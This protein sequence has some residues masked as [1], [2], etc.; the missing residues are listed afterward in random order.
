MSF[1]SAAPGH[2][3]QVN[4][5]PSRNQGP[6]KLA[7]L[8]RTLSRKVPKYFLSA[9]RPSLHLPLQKWFALTV[10]DR[11]LPIYKGCSIMRG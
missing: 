10:T 1:W 6:A 8:V 9:I 3:L 2:R 11:I 7:P 5:D 4:P